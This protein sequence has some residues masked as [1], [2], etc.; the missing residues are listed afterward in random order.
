MK[1]N[2]VVLIV[3]LT[4][5]LA[6]GVAA[7]ITYAFLTS[8]TESGNLMITKS[9]TLDIKYTKGDDITGSLKQTTSRVGGLSTEVTI[10]KTSA[11]V[12]ASANIYI[13]PTTLSEELRVAGLKWEVVGS[14]GYNNNGTFYGAIENTPIPIVVNHELT[15]TDTTFTIYIWLNGNQVGSEVVGTTFVGK[16]YAESTQVY[17]TLD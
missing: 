10:S 13:I 16:I 15:T 5:L 1:K 6:L 12:D 3:L 17:G 4:V 14:N 9:G 2:T 8:K 11:S 7:T